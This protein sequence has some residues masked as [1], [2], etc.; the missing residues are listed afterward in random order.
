MRLKLNQH[1][2]GY[3]SHLDCDLVMPLV[4]HFA[5]KC[6]Y[7]STFVKGGFITQFM[8]SRCHK[9]KVTERSTPLVPVTVGSVYLTL[10]GVCPSPA[11]PAGIFA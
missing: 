9:C 11:S 2:F 3:F 7:S 6:H 4:K 1:C 8:H 5:P 10:L